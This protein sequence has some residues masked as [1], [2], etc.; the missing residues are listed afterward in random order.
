[1]FTVIVDKPR[2]AEFLKHFE[3]FARQLRAKGSSA[4]VPAKPIAKGP[5]AFGRMI[6]VSCPE[7]FLEYLDK[8]SFPHQYYRPIAPPTS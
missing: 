6:Y 7:S 1:L 5:N 3:D 2:D 8:V 4:S